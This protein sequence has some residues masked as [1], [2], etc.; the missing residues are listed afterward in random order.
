MIGN[1]KNFVY[2]HRYA[3][4]LIVIALA[5]HI[6]WF[7]PWSLLESGDWQF[8]FNE[9]VKQ[10]Y[11]S[12]DTWVGFEGSGKPNIMLF[13]YPI[14]GILWSAI[15][16]I[17]LS[18]D[19]AVKLTMFIPLALGGFLI[20]YFI[21]R[22]LVKNDFTAFTGALFYA[23]TTYF[24]LIQSRHLPIGIIYIL[25]PLFF[26][27]AHLLFT[28]NKM[29][30][31]V[32]AALLF[33]IGMFYEL[34]IMYIVF[35]ILGIY[36]LYSFFT[37][38]ITNIKPYVKPLLLACGL[39]LL[40]N[41]F[42]ILPTVAG[43]AGTAIGQTAN[44]GL[45]GDALFNMSQS[46]TIFRWS[47]TG[48]LE[49]RSF[50]A[51]PIQWYLWIPPIIA[52]S[53]LLYKNRYKKEL[54]FFAII[55][56]LG[57]FLTKQSSPP[58]SW[59]YLWLYEHFPGF[60][61]F[62]EASKFYVMTAFAYWG[63][64]IYGL[65]ALHE[66]SFKFKN[67]LYGAAA[68]AV[69]GVALLNLKPLFTREIGATFVSAQL[70]NDYIMLKDFLRNQSDYSRTLWVPLAAPW[71]YYDN[72]H[73][74]LTSASDL[75]S[76]QWNFL[77][78]EPASVSFS[79]EHA[80]RPLKQT[81]SNTLLDNLSVKYVVVPIRYTFH[82]DDQ[83]ISY[84][85]REDSD[86][87]NSY[88]SELNKLAFLKRIDIGTEELA[89]YENKNH[90]PYI[91]ASTNTYFLRQPADLPAK[92]KLLTSITGE[93]INFVEEEAKQAPLRNVYDIFADL[94]RA[95]QKNN[96]ISKEVTIT[97]NQ[98]LYANTNYPRLSYT[99]AAN[100]FSFH[101]QKNHDITVKSQNVAMTAPKDRQLIVS[102]PLHP[103]RSYVLAIGDRLMP[104][105]TKDTD[106]SLGPV[107]ES[108]QLLTKS[109]VNLISNP[110]FEAG[111][112][113]KSTQDCS[114]DS[115]GK[116]IPPI[117]DT[118]DRTE[119]RQSLSL[120]SLTH[121][122]CTRQ[123]VPLTEGKKYS[124]AFD[125]KIINGERARYKIVFN[126]SQ[127]TSI[128][129]S[130]MAGGNSWRSLARLVTAPKGA[131]AMTLYLYAYSNEVPNDIASTLYDNF[132]LNELELAANA[133]IDLKPNYQ[134]VT[135]PKEGTYTFT[136]AHPDINHT[137]LIPNPS[138]EQGL[139]QKQV[140]D[141][142]AYD[143]RAQLGMRPSTTAKTDGK[144]SL[145]LTA[146]LHIAC[147]GPP[148]VNVKENMQY[149]LKFD[150]QSPNAPRAG[151]YLS[152]NDPA[153]TAIYERLPIDDSRW[154]TLHK[155]VQ[156]PM[157]ATQ[158]KLIVYAY[159]REPG[160]ETFINRYDNFSLTQTPDIR[161]QFYVVDKQKAILKQPNNVTSRVVSGT[162]KSVQVKG[163]RTPFYLAMNESYN[164]KWRLELDNSKVNGPINGTMPW[165]KADAVPAATHFKLNGYANGWYVDPAALC[166]DASGCTRNNDGSYDL[167]MTIEF[168]PQRWF[169][170]GSVISVAAFAGITGYLFVTW[171]LQK[172]QKGRQRWWR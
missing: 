1:I 156:A 131:T 162:K 68:I 143:N 51:Q 46:L 99:I 170:L 172:R 79:E 133:G 171:R 31:W 134:P 91:A 25:T 85:G 13:S 165:A 153:R 147:T 82:D 129:E 152:F 74:K 76:Q 8:R 98:A 116:A 27:I 151:Y 73:P 132:Q 40:A 21:G 169:Y 83:F 163:A 127:Q 90:K 49:D 62:R 84:G 14:R 95:T 140:S 9:H 78:R 148:V 88:I 149:L 167:A 19:I 32:I 81:L 145:E 158:A 109:T 22:K 56:A 104:V 6:Q 114:P 64:L 92:Y 7:N 58:F 38:D 60:N 128:K 94:K 41:A 117:L 97:H 11:H 108:V 160:S 34:R 3:I 150:Y 57:L 67:L 135:L 43:S 66:S 118:E 101:A 23:T 130:L 16:A 28:K 123:K 105:D 47:W 44:R 24:L 146:K 157:G 55:A 54:F 35:I 155:Y 126:D 93:N 125:Y 52:F 142:N 161:H 103:N 37:K 107:N 4:T 80:L 70:P 113:Q 63:L 164:A 86:I 71:S 39:L 124:L 5:T 121:V 36:A 136:Y 53:S 30:Y 111:L 159:G 20:P 77:D 168:T 45:F 154:H 102:Q 110:S 137:N 106:R 75:N 72:S 141:C 59:S 17:G 96:N 15:T 50:T 144:Q 139:W 100:T 122:A 29:F 166:Q 48:T 87:R 33:S 115:S 12:W 69:I 42:W 65:R 112:W 26:Y 18:Y 120:N 138:L 10:L 119:G 61:L 89:I 2:L